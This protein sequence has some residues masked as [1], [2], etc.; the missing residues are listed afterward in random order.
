MCFKNKVFFCKVVVGY[1]NENWRS[2]IELKIFSKKLKNGNSK[3]YLGIS[4]DL[5]R[6]V[7]GH[8]SFR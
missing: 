6:A 1:K 8:V 2:N 4:L 5:L 3:I 7:W